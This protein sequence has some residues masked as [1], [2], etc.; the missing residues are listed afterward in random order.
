MRQ[1]R[2]V[3]AV[4][5]V[6]ACIPL[7]L[8]LRTV[9]GCN[10]EKV[11]ILARSLDLAHRPDRLQAPRVAR[12]NIEM[13]RRCL[14]SAP[15]DIDLY[16]LMGR[17]LAFLGRRAEAVAI[18]DKALQIDRRPEILFDIGMLEID[19]NRHDDAVRH[20][21]AACSFNIAL[22]EEIPYWK[23]RYEVLDIVNRRQRGI[24]ERARRH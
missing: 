21:V 24:I 23:E 17:N 6:V 19:L 8:T 12:E 18:L 14:Q 3:L 7:L 2:V 16:L 15:T 4:V 5:V 13:I 20:L 11:G 22:N 10:R 9:W 1:I